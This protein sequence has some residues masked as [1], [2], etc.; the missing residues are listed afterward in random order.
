MT[1]ATPT[2]NGMRSPVGMP[3]QRPLHLAAGAED[4]VGVAEHGAPHVGEHQPA[5]AGARGA[6]RRGAPSSVFSWLEMVGWERRS[7]WLALA[8]LPARATIQK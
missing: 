3:L 7:S 5:A 8:M 1:S 4:V 2:A 6:G